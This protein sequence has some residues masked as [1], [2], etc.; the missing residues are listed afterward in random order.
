MDTP[1]CKGL[2]SRWHGHP[3]THS[4]MLS[5]LETHKHAKPWRHGFYSH[6]LLFSSFFFSVVSFFFV[7]HES[8]AGTTILTPFLAEIFFC[9]H[10]LKLRWKLLFLFW[11]WK[12]CNLLFSVLRKISKPHSQSLLNASALLTSPQLIFLGSFGLPSNS[13]FLKSFFSSLSWL[14]NSIVSFFGNHCKNIWML[15]SLH[16]LFS[17]AVLG[18][19]NQ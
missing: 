7:F 14:R 8:T 4:S 3:F 18:I 10:P 5:Q 2:P 12:K 13:C 17:V 16:G 6:S 11:Q 9:K 1:V 19:Y 15:C